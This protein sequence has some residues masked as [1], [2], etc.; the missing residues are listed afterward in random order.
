MKDLLKNGREEKGFSTR[1][2]AELTDIDQALISKFENGFR[3]PT[4]KQIQILSQ[5][6]EID[7]KQ[8]LVAWYKVKLEHSFDINPF[9]IQAITEIL[10]EKGIEV[11]NNKE[12]EIN[13]ILDEIEILKQKLTNLR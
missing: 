5:L 9:A 7:L 11:G 10:Q 8:L 1:K 6:L 2:L 4:K 13:S 3:I 12:K